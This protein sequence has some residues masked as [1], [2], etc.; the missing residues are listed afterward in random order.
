MENFNEIKEVAERLKLVLLVST[1]TGISGFSR[2]NGGAQ[3][4][5]T[6]FLNVLRDVARKCGKTATQVGNA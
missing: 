6:F 3:Q 4:P 2:A 1:E 5:G